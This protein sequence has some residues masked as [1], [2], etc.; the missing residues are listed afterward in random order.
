MAFCV[1]C[2]AQLEENARF[3]S[4][5]GARQ[6]DLPTGAAAPEE[7]L[8]SYPAADSAAECGAQDFGQSTPSYDPTVYSPL[9]KPEKKKGGRILALVVLALVALAAIVYIFAGKSG[10]KNTAG[11]DD[12]GLYVAQAGEMNGLSINIENLWDDGFT[13]ELK[14]KG[15]AE[16]SIGGEKGSAKW[17][18]DGDKFTVKGSG[19]DCSGTLKNGV[20]TLENAM[21]SGVTLTFTKDGAAL[22]S[23]DV[24][25]EEPAVL[26]A[27]E[28]AET[29]DEQ[30][31]P[32]L[33]ENAADDGVLGVYYA[34]KAVAY[35]MDVAIS[36][37]WEN[38]YSLE[39]Q[40]DGKCI[41][42]F[43]GSTSEAAW[44][45]EGEI[46]TLSEDGI[47][48]T[49]TLSG[50]VLIFENIMD[51]GVD[52]YFTK[53]GSMVPVETTTNAESAWSGDYYGWWA[54]LDP[55][56]EFVVDDDSILPA[57]DVCASITDYGDGTG[58]LLIWDEDN[59]MLVKAGVTFASG[60]TEKGTM[61]CRNG[62]FWDSELKEGDWV[63]EPADSMVSEFADM[64]CID[65]KYVDP[66]NPDNSL[67]YMI[68]LRPWGMRWDDVAAADTTNMICDDMTPI[69]YNNWYLPLIEAGEP[70]PD[71]FD[72][73]Y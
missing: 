11:S 31:Q 28:P 45:L 4:N 44:K 42:T 24:A 61:A 22:P 67:E 60:L 40:E 3:C 7:P 21:D 13:I 25:A 1:Q 46:F 18:L 26:P 56:G 58:Y 50:G 6:P 8:I 59:D 30:E 71:S 2:G 68:F 73:L 54:V 66:E 33:A 63:V 35:G 51:T 47:D 53:D 72:G 69:A 49:G 19:I 43:D 64:L 5:C 16:I 52:I 12:L 32:A 57:W 15:K 17:T 70:M 27:E 38:G 20:L 10:G 62:N 37:I 9:A 14:D 41:A 39:L 65:G 55:T 48:L 34:D 23:A 29:P 36:T